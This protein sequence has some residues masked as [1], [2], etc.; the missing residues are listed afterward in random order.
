MTGV[1]HLDVLHVLDRLDQIDAAAV[2]GV[3]L[4][5]RALDFRVPGVSDEEHLARL[6][7]IARD[8]HVHFRHQRTGRIEH[9]ERAALRLHL[10]GARHAVG[11]EDHRR[12]VG[13]LVELLDEHRADGAQPIDHVLVV[14]HLVAHVDGRAEQVDGALDD[15]D[16]A[17]DA[18]A[19]AAWIG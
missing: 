8:F 18:G 2:R 10:D 19:E 11:A 1:A 15:V 9:L 3:E 16:G 17:V 6:A 7:R 14:H 13:H 5:D 12:A 4:T